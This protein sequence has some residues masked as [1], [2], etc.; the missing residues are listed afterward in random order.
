MSGEFA[1]PAIDRVPR[2]RRRIQLSEPA[3]SFVT[4]IAVWMLA[5]S[6]VARFRYDL[7]T[8]D[9]ASRDPRVMS[10][11]AVAAVALLVAVVSALVYAVDHR[12]RRNF[13]PRGYRAPLKARYTVVEMLFGLLLLAYTAAVGFSGWQL[14]V[15]GAETRGIERLPSTA[16]IVFLVVVAAVYVYHL[17]MLPA[18]GLTF[19]MSRRHTR[20][21]PDES[22]REGPGFGRTA[23]ALM[24]GNALV[25]AALVAVEGSVA[26]GLLP[27]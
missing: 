9:A 3:V 18:V 11:F 15:I 13:H 14:G 8:I 26:A 5:L 27:T 4:S 17:L 25:F 22:M 7:S 1:D 24:V 12:R 19:L 23:A 2:I 16:E 10:W 20:Q 21:Y 6:G